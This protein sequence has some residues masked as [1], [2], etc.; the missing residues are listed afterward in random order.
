MNLPFAS[1]QGAALATT[2]IAAI[3]VAARNDK[4]I[5][6]GFIPRAT[7]NESQEKI[8]EHF[9]RAQDQHVEIRS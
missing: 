4:M 6:I 1:L 2:G 9:G 3:E 7:L 8:V 5:F